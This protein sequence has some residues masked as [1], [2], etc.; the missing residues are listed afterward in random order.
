MSS[1]APWAETAQGRQA[2]EDAMAER[3]KISV[4]PVG[5]LLDLRRLWFNILVPS[6]RIYIKHRL[7]WIARS[8]R[9][10]NYWGGWHAEVDFPPP[11][12]NHTRVGTG[13]T[14]K[15]AVR[16]LGVQLWKD[17]A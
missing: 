4:Y 1:L 17:N 2:L 15:R 5:L 16:D 3:T 6:E 14:R 13:W 10:R 12:L 7:R 8:W 11:G 9:R